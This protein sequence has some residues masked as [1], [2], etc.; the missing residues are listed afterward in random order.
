VTELCDAVSNRVLLCEFSL[1]ITW[2]LKNFIIRFFCGETLWQ[3][4]MGGY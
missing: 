1:H 4:E 2:V 3:M